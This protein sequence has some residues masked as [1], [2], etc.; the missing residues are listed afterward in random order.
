MILLKISLIFQYEFRM[1]NVH[2]SNSCQQQQVGMAL[3]TSNSSSR[4][5]FLRQQ[6]TKQWHWGLVGRG[7][8]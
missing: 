8:F 1:N 4:L 2:I 3:E 7:H 5:M 6:T